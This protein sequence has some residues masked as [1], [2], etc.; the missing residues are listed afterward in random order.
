MA[1]AAIPRPY[2]EGEPWIPERLREWLKNPRKVRS[3]AVMPP[4]VLDEGEGERIAELTAKRLILEAD[5][6]QVNR[7]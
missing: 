5:S 4:L 6:R 3:M 2:C 7:R 1:G